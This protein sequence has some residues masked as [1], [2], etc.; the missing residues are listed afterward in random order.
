MATAAAA[1]AIGSA[2]REMERGVME[3]AEGGLGKVLSVLPE[4]PMSVGGSPRHG[5]YEGTD[6]GWGR[7]CRVEMVSIEKTPGTV[8]LAEGPD[9]EGGVEVE[10]GVVLPPDAMEAFASCFSDIVRLS[11]KSV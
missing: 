4:R 2:I 11:G 1:A 8:S 9:G 3:G 5:V 6:F 7:P 10:V